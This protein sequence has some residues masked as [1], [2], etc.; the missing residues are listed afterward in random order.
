MKRRPKRRVKGP[1]AAAIATPARRHSH[2]DITPHR[3]TVRRPP[4]VH[5]PRPGNQQARSIIAARPF[6]SL[7]GCRTKFAPTHLVL[8][9]DTTEPGPRH[10]LPCPMHRR[11]VRSSRKLSDLWHGPGA[12]GREPRRAALSVTR[13]MTPALVGLVLALAGRRPRNGR[14]S[15]RRH[16]VRSTLST[17][18]VRL[19]HTRVLWAGWPVFVRGWHCSSRAIST[20]HDCSRGPP[21]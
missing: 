6:I 17:E 4:P 9:Q 18:F 3:C 8:E 14:P 13:D 20:C 19:R 10:Q 21:A 5:I 16:A 12:G 7:A 2:H 15:R 1:A 11:S